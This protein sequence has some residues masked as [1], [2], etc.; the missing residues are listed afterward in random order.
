MLLLIRRDMRLLLDDGWGDLVVPGQLPVAP[1]TPSSDAPARPLGSFFENEG[2]A[3]AAARRDPTRK[4]L[5]ERRRRDG[6]GWPEGHP[7]PSSYDRAVPSE[8]P[9]RC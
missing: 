9:I 5:H 8:G 4:S 1:R 7:S 6:G 3:G 2:T